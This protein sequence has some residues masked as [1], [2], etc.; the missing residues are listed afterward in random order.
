MAA[1]TRA[2]PLHEPSPGSLAVLADLARSLVLRLDEIADRTVE[3]ILER[4]PGYRQERYLTLA[5]LRR[6]VH[7]SLAEYL[8]A[9][10]LLP[11]GGSPSKQQAWATGRSRAELGVPLESVLRAYRLGGSVIWEELLEEAR[12]RPDRPGDELMEAAYLV[13]QL[14]DE[15][16]AAVGTAYRH[17]EAGMVSR[18]QTRRQG[19]LRGLLLGVL[20]DRELVFAA[21]S[22]GLPERGPYQVVVAQPQESQLGDH[23]AAVGVRSEWVVQEG[24]TCGLLALATGG[25]EAVRTRL[26]QVGPLRAGISPEFSELSGAGGAYR[27][28]ELALRTILA[29]Q[30]VVASL[31]DRLPSALLISS[32]ELARRLALAVLGRV[33]GLP[34]AERRLLLRTLAIFLDQ[35]GSPGATARHV[36]CHRNTVLNRLHRIR[37]LTGCDPATPG[38]ASR[39]LLGLQAAELLSMLG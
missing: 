11:R 22:L 39:L 1:V 9:L 29:H 3:A 26:Q 10:A 7:D 35:D 37:E 38:G 27:Q 36:P 20:A 13:W 33:L 21:E 25:G 34:A 30:H 15:L 14:T 2:E 5:E 24:R 23:L 28:A 31:D 17:S 12:R 19:L 16:S 8:G 18:D 6:S 32:P 4:E